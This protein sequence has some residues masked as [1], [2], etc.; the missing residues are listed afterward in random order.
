MLGPVIG[1]NKTPSANGALCRRCCWGWL[2]AAILLH[3]V[4]IKAQ[5]P[6]RQP[7]GCGCS[8]GRR[9]STGA[10]LFGKNSARV[11]V[12]GFRPQP[13]ASASE[14]ELT[15]CTDLLVLGQVIRLLN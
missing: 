12:T 9:F 10:S 5:T 7:Q 1:C 11:L 2:L 8:D 15:Q 13:S 14:G 4:S 3:P 6:R